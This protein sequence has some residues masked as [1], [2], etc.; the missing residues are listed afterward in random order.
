VTD[1]SKLSTN[2]LFECSDAAARLVCSELSK[3]RAN[4]FELPE[5]MASWLEQYVAF[6]EEGDRRIHKAA[7][8]HDEARA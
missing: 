6:R 8:D 7:V 3:A 4:G 5:P 2:E 1:F